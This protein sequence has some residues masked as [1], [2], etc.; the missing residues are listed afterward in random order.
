MGGESSSPPLPL[1]SFLFSFIAQSVTYTYL[2]H[3]VPGSVPIHQ[4]TDSHIFTRGQT[5]VLAASSPPLLLSNFLLN[6]EKTLRAPTHL[7]PIT[8]S[9]I[10]I[11]V[12]SFHT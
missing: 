7:F 5:R 3:A 8:V 10:G 12:I 11:M 1:I 6:A 2:P 9:H 4:K